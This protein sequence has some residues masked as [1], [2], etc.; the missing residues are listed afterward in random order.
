MAN[1]MNGPDHITPLT[2]EQVK[3]R[4][5]RSLAIGWAVAAMALLF[6]VV[7]YVRLGDDMLKQHKPAPRA[8]PGMQK[9]SLHLPLP[10]APVTLPSRV[11]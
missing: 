9:G 11:G 1:N 5:G 8:V 7:T 4:R 2:P 10:R 3:Q 6:A